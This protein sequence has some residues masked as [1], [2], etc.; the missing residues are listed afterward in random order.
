MTRRK[1]R[2]DA[3]G[4]RRLVVVQDGVEGF[5]VRVTDSCSGCFTAGECGG[6]AGCYPFDAK[7][8]C[9]VGAGCH[10][11]GHTGKRRR[12]EWSPFLGSP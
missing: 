11:C 12:V 4:Q 6:V 2:R 10:E 5:M 8:G 3:L 7:A 9:R 1:Y